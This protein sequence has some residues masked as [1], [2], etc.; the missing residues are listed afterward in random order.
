MAPTVS[1]VVPTYN[2]LHFLR[3]AVESVFAQSFCDWELIIADDGSDEE[4]RAYLRALKRPQQIEVLW[5]QHSGRPGAARNAALKQAR[6]DFVA[7]LDSD[8]LWLPRKLERQMAS[9]HRWPQR[10]WSCTAFVLVGADGSPRADAGSGSQAALSGNI[11]EKLL[12]QEVVIALPSVVVSR[13]LLQRSGGFDDELLVSEDEDLWLRL[14]RLSEIDV[15]GEPLTLVRRH[16]EH[17]SD[18]V[19]AWRD[20]R[21]VFERALASETDARRSAVLRRIRAEMSAG[22]ARSQSVA[23]LRLGAL[24]TLLSSAVY[25]WRSRRWWRSSVGTIARALAPAVL[26]SAWRRVRHL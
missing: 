2:R 21:R 6:G 24:D 19:T 22:L 14:A 4:T 25:S 8:D 23:G 9:L 10:Q 20:R 1:V 16:R 26:R 7:F 18:D 12:G 13:A 17:S 3:P 5:L 15:V 11:S